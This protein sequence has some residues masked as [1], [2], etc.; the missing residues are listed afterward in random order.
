MIKPLTSYTIV[1]QLHSKQ[2]LVDIELQLL[3]TIHFLLDDEVYTKRDAAID[4]L[5]VL[6]LV[7]MQ[8]TSISLKHIKEELSSKKTQ[9]AK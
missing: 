7:E 2:V 8:E 1:D 3:Q 9:T 6:A 5:S 4:L